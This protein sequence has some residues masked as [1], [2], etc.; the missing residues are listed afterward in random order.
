MM[1]GGSMFIH[2]KGYLYKTGSNVKEGKYVLQ[3]H[4]FLHS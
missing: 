3:L 2:H 4:V 1:I